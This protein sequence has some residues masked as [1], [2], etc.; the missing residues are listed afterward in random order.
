MLVVRQEM[1]RELIAEKLCNAV[2]SVE[3]LE[4]GHVLLRTCHGWL[5][6]GC[7]LDENQKNTKNRSIQQA[8]ALATKCNYTFSHALRSKTRPESF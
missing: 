8:R 1:W 2:F 7:K 5:K 6:P 3:K 4:W